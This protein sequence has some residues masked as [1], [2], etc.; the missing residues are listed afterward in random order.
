MNRMTGW[1]PWLALGAL[2]LLLIAA[3]YLGAGQLQARA[4]TGSVP[5]VLDR[6]LRAVGGLGCCAGGAAA[7]SGAA[8]ANGCGQ[9]S[10]PAAGATDLAAQAEQAARERWQREGG[11]SDVTFRVQDYGCHIEVQVYRG[12]ERVHTYLYVPGSGIIDAG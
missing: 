8:A 5:P 11:A 10:V 9:R 2:G 4:A 7:A 3:L 1:I 6:G 12:S